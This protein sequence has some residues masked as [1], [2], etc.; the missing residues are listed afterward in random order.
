M[1]KNIAY[2]LHIDISTDASFAAPASDDYACKTW[3]VKKDISFSATAAAAAGEE[4]KCNN[5]SV[6]KDTRAACKEFLGEDCFGVNKGTED[7]PKWTCC[8]WLKDEIS[9]KS[10]GTRLFDN[11]YLASRLSAQQINR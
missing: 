7:D 4:Y 6:K 2:P 3:T 8:K 9:A 11:D 10:E 5:F 1:I